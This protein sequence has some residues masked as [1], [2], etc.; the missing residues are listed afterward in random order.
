MTEELPEYDRENRASI[1]GGWCFSDGRHRWPVSDCTAEAL[2][3]I[4]EIENVPALIPQSARIDPARIE[5]AVRFLV[6]RQN[7]DGGFGTYEATRGAEW[8]EALNPSEMFRDCM[9]EHSYVECTASAVEAL[10]IVRAHYP[11]MLT[12]VVSRTLAAGIGLLSVT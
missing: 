6:A 3:A 4:I 5:E 8:L 7:P 1:V 10:A 2:A 9:T 11:R 12:E